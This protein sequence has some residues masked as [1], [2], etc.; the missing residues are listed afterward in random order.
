[1]LH[2]VLI[3]THL[4]PSFLGCCSLI[5]SLHSYTTGKAC[6]LASRRSW[7]ARISAR[8]T[9]RP[10]TKAIYTLCIII[11]RDPICIIF[12][13]ISWFYSIPACCSTWRGCQS[14]SQVEPNTQE[15]THHCTTVCVCVCVCVHIVCWVW[16]SFLF[17][18]FTTTLATC[19]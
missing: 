12:L 16:V 18:S 1:M 8:E 6:S 7:G 5:E 15:E 14:G 17:S 4:H 13:Y 2:N 10:G 19:M 11:M 9:R 3:F